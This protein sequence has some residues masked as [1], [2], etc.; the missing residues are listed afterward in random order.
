MRWRFCL[1]SPGADPGGDF[2]MMEQRSTTSRRS[3]GPDREAH[4]VHHPWQV[5]RGFVRG[6]IGPFMLAWR[7]RLNAIG[8]GLFTTGKGLPLWK[9]LLDVS[10]NCCLSVVPALFL[11]T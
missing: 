10:Q 11:T 6:G 7:R 9:P 2:W 8:I 4:S 3:I 5:A 1:S